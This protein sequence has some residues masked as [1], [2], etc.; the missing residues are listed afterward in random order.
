MF[1]DTEA[2]TNLYQMVVLGAVVGLNILVFFK[3]GELSEILVGALVGMMT[4]I[5]VINKSK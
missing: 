2:M 5:G 1:K 3:T 4:G